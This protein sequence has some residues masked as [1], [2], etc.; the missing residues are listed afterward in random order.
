MIFILAIMLIINSYVKENKIEQVQENF[1]S[2]KGFVFRDFRTHVESIHPDLEMFSF[3]CK[4]PIKPNQKYIYCSS[5]F[6]LNHE[7]KNFSAKC[8]IYGSGCI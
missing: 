4:K 7:K 8:D 2:L 3:Y 6:Y 5:T 1:E